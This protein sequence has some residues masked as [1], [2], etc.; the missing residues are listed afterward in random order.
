MGTPEPCLC[1]AHTQ[2]MSFLFGHCA[3][4][5]WDRRPAPYPQQGLTQSV[6]LSLT[7]THAHTHTPFA[8]VPM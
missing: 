2:V 3:L 7:H 1:V 4:L 8:S 6:G 5:F